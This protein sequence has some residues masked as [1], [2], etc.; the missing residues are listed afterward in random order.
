M[1][2]APAILFMSMSRILFNMDEFGV[3]VGSGDIQAGN[4]ARM[5]LPTP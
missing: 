3:Y 5:T 1:K 2:N 4:V